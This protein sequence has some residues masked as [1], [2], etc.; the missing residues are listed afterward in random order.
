MAVRAK[1][2]WLEVFMMDVTLD[3]TSKEEEDMAAVLKNDLTYNYVVMT[4]T[5]DA[6][7]Y[8]WAAETVN[9]HGDACKA[10]EGL[11]E[12]YQSNGK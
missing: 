2:G 11:Y 1:E 6:F 8:M 3:R 9:S 4:C 5:D 12:R 7:E 10:W